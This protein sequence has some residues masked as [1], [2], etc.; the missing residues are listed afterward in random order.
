MLDAKI[1]TMIQSVALKDVLQESS[2]N[3]CHIFLCFSS[4]K[5]S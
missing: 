1:Y 2:T 5:I 3:V 4:N